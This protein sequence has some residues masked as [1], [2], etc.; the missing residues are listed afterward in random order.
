MTTFKNHIKA[1]PETR[2]SRRTLKPTTS[3]RIETGA[4]LSPLPRAVDATAS[5]RATLPAL[6]QGEGQTSSSKVNQQPMGSWPALL[7]NLDVFLSS[8]VDYHLAIG[9]SCS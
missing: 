4:M 5:R 2:S 1:S 9:H 6:G 8:D 7:L 3:K